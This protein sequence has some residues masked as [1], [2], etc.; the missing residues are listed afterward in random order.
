MRNSIFLLIFGVI[1][2]LPTPVLASDL[3]GNS[4]NSGVKIL[5]SGKSIISNNLRSN[6]N[7][8]V[9]FAGAPQI[10]GAK[11]QNVIGNA[12][13]ASISTR[14]NSLVQFGT[15]QNISSRA[16]NFI[17]NSIPINKGTLNIRRTTSSRTTNLFD[18][19]VK[20]IL[21]TAS[22]TF[23][24]LRNSYPIRMGSR[25][26]AEVYGIDIAEQ[27][28][29]TQLKQA[30]AIESL[31]EIDK[32]TNKEEKMQHASNLLNNIASDPNVSKKT[33][34]EINNKINNTFINSE[35]KNLWEKNGILAV[36]EEGNLSPRENAILKAFNEILPTD[37]AI[38]KV[39]FIKSHANSADK[40]ILGS[41]N[42][43]TNL[44]TAFFGKDIANY[45]LGTLVH[46]TSHFWDNNNSFGGTFNNARQY[47]WNASNKLTDFS[48]NYG[49]S[50]ILEDMATTFEMY[51][52]NTKLLFT[53]GLNNLNGTP[54]NSPSDTLL[55]KA[56]LAADFF[57]NYQDGKITYPHTTT[58][59]EGTSNN[60]V[61]TQQTPYK[62]INR[63]SIQPDSGYRVPD[64]NK[65]SNQKTYN[66]PSY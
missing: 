12:N 42:R 44:I 37:K 11:V 21:T 63:N 62:I 36:K 33:K 7:T 9:K 35:N 31:K 55:M 56:T 14:V 43:A 10:I 52:K 48:R 57:T 5:N 4:L 64:F 17:F 38:P 41:T 3:I 16:Q 2:T 24:T 20:N 51:G 6:L 25:N 50:N 53:Q 22:S 8:V 27:P 23:D 26:Q 66:F 60:S 1:T 15:L 32:T 58:T 45:E 49:A 29:N 34:N 39:F 30:I 13:L 47:L 18:K 54:N 61:T 19:T 46:E 59:T 28:N 40:D 65:S